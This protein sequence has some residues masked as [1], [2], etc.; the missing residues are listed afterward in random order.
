MS[1][2]VEIIDKKIK[3]VIELEVELNSISNHNGFFE[4]QKELAIEEF[5]EEIRNEITSNLEGDY[6]SQGFLRT[7][8]FVNYEIK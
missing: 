8:D 1:Q 7:V 4:G 3:V 5:E 2:R 6:Q